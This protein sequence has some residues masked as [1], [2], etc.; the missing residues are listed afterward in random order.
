MANSGNSTVHQTNAVTSN[1]KSIMA[2]LLS[3]K[4]NQG[5]T[6]GT[7]AGFISSISGNTE[8]DDVRK[9]RRLLE[10]TLT[11]NMHLGT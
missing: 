9:L 5:Q 7:L 1:F 6:N 8:S 10:E 11:K 2:D 4:A 3:N